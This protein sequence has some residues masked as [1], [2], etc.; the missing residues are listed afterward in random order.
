MGAIFT[1]CQSQSSEGVRERYKGDEGKRQESE[2]HQH[3]PF[4]YFRQLVLVMS[5]RSRHVVGEGVAFNGQ[6]GIKRGDAGSCD[7]HLSRNEPQGN[8]GD[9]QLLTPPSPSPQIAL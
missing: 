4:V 6:E 3:P 2:G 5:S 7:Y 8:G 1:A 9:E